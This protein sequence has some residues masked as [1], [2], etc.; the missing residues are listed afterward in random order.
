M[1]QGFTRDVCAQ[2]MRR[3]LRSCNA[4]D[5][6][7]LLGLTVALLQRPDVC[8]FYNNKFR[9]ICVDE[10]QV[11]TNGSSPGAWLQRVQVH[12]GKERAPALPSA[13]LFNAAA[14]MHPSRASRRHALLPNH[15]PH[16]CA[17]LPHP[18]I[19]PAQSVSSLSF[20]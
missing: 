13:V 6:D 19:L 17:M 9:H 11:S 16:P 1:L 7:D 15:H 20:L 4:V 10:F 2:K 18:R 12:T 5:F 14:C 3:L 8:A